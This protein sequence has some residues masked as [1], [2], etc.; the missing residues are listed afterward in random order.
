M[1]MKMCLTC[2][3]IPAFYAQTR[4]LSLH[5]IASFEEAKKLDCSIFSEKSVKVP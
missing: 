5:K 2:V 4:H 3:H 1:Q